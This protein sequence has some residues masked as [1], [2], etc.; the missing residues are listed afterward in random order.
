MR[1]VAKRR[2]RLAPDRVP[3]NVLEFFARHRR[4]EQI[5]AVAEKE[6]CVEASERVGGRDRPA[7]IGQE[8]HR[9]HQTALE[10]GRSLGALA[11]GASVRLR[12][13]I[14]IVELEVG[15]GFPFGKALERD[16]CGAVVHI[17]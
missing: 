6:P 17:L 3:D 16:V 8:I 1:D 13:P 11:D 7:D 10:I 5:P 9:C 2:K 15:G 14:G 12:K 4:A